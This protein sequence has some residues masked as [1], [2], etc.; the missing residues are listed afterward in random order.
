MKKEFPAEKISKDDE[1]EQE[2]LPMKQT[3][4]VKTEKVPKTLRKA[5]GKKPKEISSLQAF[6]R[7]TAILTPEFAHAQILQAQASQL[8]QKSPGGTSSQQI[9]PNLGI[10][11]DVLAQLS[12]AQMQLLMMQLRSGIVTPRVIGQGWIFKFLNRLF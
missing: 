10:P 3:P 4:K 11:Q 2:G 1:Y 7:N 5:I 12:P 8:L 9:L 6:K